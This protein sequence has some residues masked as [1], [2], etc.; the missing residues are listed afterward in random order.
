MT[1][2][3]QHAFDDATQ[4][5]TCAFSGDSEAVASTFDAVVDRDGVVGA[6]DVAWCLAATMVGDLPGGGGWTLDFPG[7]DDARYDKRWV[8][9]FVSAYVNGDFPTGEALFGA[10]IADGQL[11]ECLLAL[12]GSTVAT[13]RHRAA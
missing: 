7:I 13:L 11:P 9:R 2:V 4:I 8:A 5:L 1:G 6:W 12:A 10:A 3:P